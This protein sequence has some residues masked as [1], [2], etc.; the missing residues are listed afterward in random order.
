MHAACIRARTAVSFSS[1]VRR[2]RHGRP[3]STGEQRCLS[4]VRHTDHPCVMCPNDTRHGLT[5]PPSYEMSASLLTSSLQASDNGASCAFFFCIETVVGPVHWITSDGSMAPFSEKKLFFFCTGPCVQRSVRT[6]HV[7]TVTS[8]RCP[9]MAL[10]SELLLPVSH[11]IYIALMARAIAAD[12][13]HWS[14]IFDYISRH[15][16]SPVIRNYSFIIC[17]RS[18]LV[19]WVRLYVD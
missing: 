4:V 12:V 11:I 17:H 16:S 13:I 15:K 18:I 2:L 9:V 6:R 5:R 10:L 8:S 14:L 1:R 7:R 19:Y 3:D